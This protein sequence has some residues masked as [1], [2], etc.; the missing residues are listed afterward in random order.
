[1]IVCPD[2]LLSHRNSWLAAL[3]RLVELEPPSTVGSEEDQKGYWAHELQAMKDM[4][5]DFDK[6]ASVFTHNTKGGHYIKLGTAQP[7]GTI[8]RTAVNPQMLDV[9]ASVPNG[10]IYYRRHGEFHEA[11]SPLYA[12]LTEVPKKHDYCPPPL[13]K[14]V[15]V[16]RRGE[17]K[18]EGEEIVGVTLS[19]KAPVYHFASGDPAPIPGEKDARLHVLKP[20]EIPAEKQH[21]LYT[22]ADKDRPDQICDSNGQVVL[23]Q[24]K[25]CNRAECELD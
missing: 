13:P 21:V 5:A 20:I 8:R 16:I 15:V 3:E 24:C 14:G 11:M 7:A 6:M 23:G 18:R 1:M 10:Q 2:N 19:R 22:D 25:N 4:Y 12:S 9:Y 17:E